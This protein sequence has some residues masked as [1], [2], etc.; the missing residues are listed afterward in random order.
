LRATKGDAARGPQELLCI[1]PD[2]RPQGQCPRA[3]FDPV[4]QLA[5][6]HRE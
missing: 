1:D 4:A 5:V 6:I 3:F 2:D